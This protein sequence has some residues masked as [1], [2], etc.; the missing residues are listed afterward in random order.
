MPTP[1]SITLPM[2]M[3]IGAPARPLVKVGDLVN[4]GTPIAEAVG[5]VS[6]PIFSG[7]SG[8]VTKISDFLL[9]N[10]NT[11]PAVTIESDGEMT[12]DPAICPPLVESREALVAAIRG[13]GVVGL[14]GAGFPTY[15]KF[16]ADPARVE[17]LIINGA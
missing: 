7:V 4:V 8:K 12:V 17:A 2:S 14:G 11:A 1:K 3:H 5:A 6:S 15:V 13:S 16:N 10:C 9:A